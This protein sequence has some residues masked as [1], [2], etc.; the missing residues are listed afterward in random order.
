[1]GLDETVAI[2]KV[3][4]NHEGL[5]LAQK[6]DFYKFSGFCGGCSSGDNTWSYYTV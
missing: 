4:L 5:N 2:H 1:M 6:V 3:N